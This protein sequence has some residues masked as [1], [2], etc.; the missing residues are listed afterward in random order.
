MPF[1]LSYFCGVLSFCFFALAPCVF[2]LSNQDKTIPLTAH[3]QEA[4]AQIQLSWSAPTSDSYTITHQKLFRRQEGDAWGS[5]YASLS[6][7]ALSYTDSEV[8]VG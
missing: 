8:E 1:F 3:V 4:P 7:T 5:E 6:S 2:A